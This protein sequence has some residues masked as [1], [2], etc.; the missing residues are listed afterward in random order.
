MPSSQGPHQPLASGAP[1]SSLA[2]RTTG[3]A[4]TS[5]TSL[6][7]SLHNTRAAT[8]AGRALT[9]TESETP[10]AGSS[11]GNK[12]KERED[13]NADPTAQATPVSP[14]SDSTVQ[15]AP[16]SPTLAQPPQAPTTGNIIPSINITPL[17][18]APEPI[19]PQTSSSQIASAPPEHTT[20][21]TTPA[22]TLDANLQAAIE[23]S[24]LSKFS[25]ML[26]ALQATAPLVDP[27]SKPPGLEDPDYP[28]TARVV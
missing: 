15:A 16:V 18:D 19:L 25:E 28:G 11:L 10:T 2:T 5:A 4:G 20:A 22:P 9:A 23:A 14:I 1:P 7:P 26:K 24:L 6:N 3:A 12:G 13:A 8:K 21:D 17:G 27:T